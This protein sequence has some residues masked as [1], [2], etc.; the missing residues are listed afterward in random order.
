MPIPSLEV[1][2]SG[3]LP[4]CSACAWCTTLSLEALHEAFYENPTTLIVLPQAF[5]LDPTM[6]QGVPQGPPNRL[7][8]DTLNEKWESLK[9]TI[10]RLYIEEN[11]K[12]SEVIDEVKAQYGFDAV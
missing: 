11:L 5:D 7:S 1:H 10:E 12:L 6:N 3:L 9:P 2:P 8:G 4:H